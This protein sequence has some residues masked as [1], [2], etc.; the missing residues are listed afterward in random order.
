MPARR[1]QTNKVGRSGALRLIRF[2]LVSL[3]PFDLVHHFLDQ[4][5]GSL[6]HVF[7]RRVF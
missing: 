2:A 4:D 1:Q 6:Q 3:E 7:R 5:E